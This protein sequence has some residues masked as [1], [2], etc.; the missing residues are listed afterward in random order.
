VIVTTFLTI[1]LVKK[2][3]DAPSARSLEDSESKGVKYKEADSSV[4]IEPFDS[5]IAKVNKFTEFDNCT[6]RFMKKMC[7][8]SVDFNPFLIS[9]PLS[10]AMGASYSFIVVIY[11]LA[12]ALCLLFN[13]FKVH[14]AC[15]EHKLSRYV[16]EH[17]WILLAVLQLINI[18]IEKRANMLY[19]LTEAK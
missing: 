17:L 6:E 15:I 1:R 11:F 10:L 8:L 13:V 3:I 14:R 2:R 19:A 9:L 16:L 7:E 12:G 18:I 5:K 4:H